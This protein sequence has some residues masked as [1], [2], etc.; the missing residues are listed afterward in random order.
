[1]HHQV[2]STSSSRN[3]PKT[4]STSQETF[5]EGKTATPSN[6]ASTSPVEE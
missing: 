2:T 6:Q 1:M 3:E 5:E 4:T